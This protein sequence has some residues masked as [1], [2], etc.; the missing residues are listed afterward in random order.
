MLT[1]RSLLGLAGA[2]AAGGA[3][4]L[5]LWSAPALSLAGCG[6]DSG[7]V[8]AD[9][10]TVLDAVSAQAIRPAMTALRDRAQALPP[11]LD[12]LAA[13]PSVDTL[14]AARTAW[15]DARHAYR[16]TVAFGIG[17]SD[18]IEVTAGILDEPANGAKIEELAASS[19]P[20]D[21]SRTP[22]SARGSL[23]IE[24]LLFDPA[25][26][27]AALVASF[28]APGGAGRASLLRA[29]GPDLRDRLMAVADAW[30]TGG[31]A[32]QVRTAGAGSATFSSQKSAFDALLNQALKIADRTID[33]TRRSAGVAGSDAAAPVSDRSDHTLLDLLDDLTGLEAVYGQGA[34][35]LGS[36]VAEVNP[37]ADQSMRAALSAARAALTAFP[38]PLR[39][40]SP[41]RQAAVDDLILKLRALKSALGVGVF[42]ALGTMSSF[43]DKDGD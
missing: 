3:S 23:A 11:A 37:G 33:I 40:A 29:L 30:L 16:A 15:S 38:A 22:A 2:A 19:T 14:T 42:N 34:S 28:A 39:G 31:F 36:I 43:S 6:D 9:R 32:E 26:D 25:R 20:V 1:R 12:A 4:S 8:S 5:A 18:D 35:S 13:G 27:D 41:D 7:A 17:P 10:G 24:Y 21:L